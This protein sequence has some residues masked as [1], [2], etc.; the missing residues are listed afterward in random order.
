MKFKI[1]IVLAIVMLIAVSCQDDDFDREFDPSHPVSGE[2]YVQEYYGDGSAFGPYHVQTF[3][4][5]FS[6]DSLW[7]NNIYGSGIKVKALLNADKTFGITQGKDIHEDISEDVASVSI[8][9]GKILSAD[10]IYFDVVLYDEDGEIVDQF[11]TAGH[12][13]TGLE[14]E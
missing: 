1:L 12:R 10:S 9:N 3:N 4:T 14:G 11:Y 13:W 2:W 5:S 8:S 6:K 7:V